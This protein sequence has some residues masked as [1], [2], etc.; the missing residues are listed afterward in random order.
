MARPFVYILG[1]VSDAKCKVFP[2]VSSGFIQPM[3]DA[4]NRLKASI[5]CQLHDRC[6]EDDCSETAFPEEGVSLFGG[7]C[8]QSNLLYVY[9]SIEPTLICVD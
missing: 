9:S 1:T 7:R 6:L 2:P 3:I 4:P 8:G 5:V